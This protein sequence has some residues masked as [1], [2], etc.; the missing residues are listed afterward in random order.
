MMGYK[1]QEIGVLRCQRAKLAKNLSGFLSLFNIG[2]LHRQNLPYETD[3]VVIKVN[4]LQYQDEL[5]YT[6]KSP[7]VGA[8]KST[9]SKSGTGFIYFFKVNILSK[10]E[11]LER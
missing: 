1:Q 11:E 8:M 3:G 4:S 10:L 9:N 2:T 7:L 5:G 6:A